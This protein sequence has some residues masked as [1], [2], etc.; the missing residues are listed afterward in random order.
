MSVGTLEQLYL[1]ML[2]DGW[3]ANR[4]ASTAIKEMTSQAHEPR[5]KEALEATAGQLNE[6]NEELADLIEAFD[7]SPDEEHCKGMEGLVREARD[8]ATKIVAPDDVQDASIIAQFQRLAHYLIAGNGTLVALARELGKSDHVAR[9]E[10]HLDK[11]YETDKLM[12]RIAENR[13]NR[14]AA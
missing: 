13:V 9:L 3:S 4:Q 11:S 12:S 2:Q 6:A 8:H 10:K 5:L 14:K 7:A 1:D